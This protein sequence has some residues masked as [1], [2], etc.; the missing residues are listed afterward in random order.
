LMLFVWHIFLIAN[1]T[2]NMLLNHSG[3]R[4]ARFA[5]RFFPLRYSSNKHPDWA[6]SHIFYIGAH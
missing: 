5:R 6:P 1:H 4:K 2:D 3:I